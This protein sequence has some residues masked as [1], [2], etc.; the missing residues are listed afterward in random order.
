[1]TAS[2]LQLLFLI[3][4]PAV[5]I[6]AAKRNK[7]LTWL[8]PVVLCYI[9]G[10]LAGN[11]YFLPID[12]ALSTNVVEGTV[13]I[14]IILLLFPTDFIR[15][16]KYAR[17]TML[18]FFLCIIAVT[19]SAV[20][21]T[22]IFKGVF[23]ES[24][25]IAGMMIGVYTGGTPNMSAIGL[26]LKVSEE[27]FIL[28]N[29]SDVIIGGFY[30]IFLMT[31]AQR[32]LLRFLPAFE[33]HKDNK[34]HNDTEKANKFKDLKLKQ[35]V[36]NLSIAFGIAVLILSVG[37]GFSYLI[38]N[39][40]AEVIVILTITTLA[41]M[42]SFLN[43][44]RNLDGAF[45]LGEYLLL[46]FCIA[47][48]TLANFNELFNASIMIFYYVAFVMIT[49]ITIHFILAFIFRIDADT[50]IITSTAGIFGPAF[51]GPIA[52]V[53]KNRDI[54]VSGLT[55]GLVGYAVANYLGIAIAYLLRP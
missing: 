43:K 16:L 50:V 18:S 29:A 54:I 46:I 51:V 27:T 31:I 21:A 5:I 42:F 25:K 22:Y 49:S 14:A 38:K 55:T 6:W 17:K 36:I 32:L 7:I 40:I 34:T 28:V 30:L 12:K 19:M 41:I 3:G 53:L 47:I 13:P 39:K 48:G 45:E 24:W 9:S 44:I 10:L 52:N 1:M 11:I 15:W 20:A 2:V 4:F 23:S 35:K 8:S 26:S 37:I 33:K